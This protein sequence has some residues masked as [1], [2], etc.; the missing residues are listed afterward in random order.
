MTAPAW[1]Q[2]VEWWKQSR[3]QWA[4]SVPTPGTE[5]G[6]N[7]MWSFMEHPD[8]RVGVRVLVASVCAAGGT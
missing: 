5:K 7:P 1:E 2:P 8:F 4:L 6:P 3:E